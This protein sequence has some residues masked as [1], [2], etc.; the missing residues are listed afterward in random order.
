M[1]AIPYDIDLPVKA[2]VYAFVGFMVAEG[3]PFM[4][5]VVGI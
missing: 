3:C 4:F 1:D 2:V 5:S